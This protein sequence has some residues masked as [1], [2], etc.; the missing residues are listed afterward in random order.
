MSYSKEPI[1]VITSVTHDGI[2]FS[3][4]DKVKI[5]D[6]Y[7][8]NYCGAAPWKNLEAEL[9][10]ITLRKGSPN[11]VGF[12]VKFPSDTKLYLVSPLGFSK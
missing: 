12:Y 2:N 7:L 1:D 9:V 8:A 3:I 4:G 10:K 5:T 6:H 11:I